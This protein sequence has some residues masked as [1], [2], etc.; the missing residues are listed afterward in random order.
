MVIERVW[1]LGFWY[2]SGKNGLPRDLDKAKYWYGLAVAQNFQPSIE[3]L[4]RLQV[5]AVDKYGKA[6]DAGDT[7]ALY[8]LATAYMYGTGGCELDKKKARELYMKAAIKGHARAQCESGI[9]A[10]AAGD[11]KEAIRWTRAAAEQNQPNSLY[12]LGIWYENAKNG[13]SKDE[14]KAKEYFQK[15]G[16]VCLCL[17]LCFH[18]THDLT[19]VCVL[20]CEMI[21]TAAQGLQVAIKAYE[22]VNI[23]AVEK[24]S[25]AAAEGDAEAQYQLATAYYCG[26]AGVAMNR[27]KARAMFLTAAKLGHALAMADSGHMASSGEGGPADKKEAVRWTEMAAQKGIACAQCNL[28]KWYEYAVNGL[29]KDMNISREYYQLAAAQN[30]AEA[31]KALERI[32]GD[33]VSRFTDA[34]ERGDANAQAALANAYHSG[35]GG[36]VI[37]HVKA[38]ALY[39]K[40]AAQGV[41]QVRR[42]F[43]PIFAVWF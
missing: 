36:V 8:D 11:A 4:R 38:R 16:T 2:E 27:V 13:L 37:D 21:K 6:A 30:D 23:D 35:G 17:C 41:V 28:G 29:P 43:E 25:A 26:R 19:C 3:P 7:D 39:Y 12:N 42:A 32:A 5:N 14:A 15:A 40:A 18:M 33:P 31:V 20:L 34:A 22:R 1:C 24:Y 10:E 9:L